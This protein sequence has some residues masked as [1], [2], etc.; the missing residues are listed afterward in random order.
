MVR[1]PDKRIDNIKL[2]A[3][4]IDGTL[5]NDKK[6]LP[7]DFYEVLD[8]MNNK[9][10]AFVIS[11]GRQIESLFLEFSDIKDR[12]YF[13]AE[14]GALIS[15][16]THI[17][18]IDAIDPQNAIT[19]I[20]MLRHIP[21]TSV[22]L[23]GEHTSFVESTDEDFLNET[24]IYYKSLKIVDDIINAVSL[25]P[26]CKFA[27]YNKNGAESTFYPELMNYKESFTINLSG[28]KWVD[29]MKSGV[30]KGAAIKHLNDSLHIS[31]DNCAAF[32]DYLN[33]YEMLLSV[34]HSF[35]MENAH[36][37]LKQISRYIAHNNNEEGVTKAIKNYLL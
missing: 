12:V 1:L 24:R 36:D 11:S 20:Q 26:V 6:E 18:H 16:G 30:S 29:V 2:I 3:T 37:K 8:E 7:S 27:I 31:P 5:M 34:T 25:E 9:D 32:G 35:A 28:N 19:L 15:R 22:I 14:N 23:C 4:D 33:D 10:I 21:D 13:I 17:F